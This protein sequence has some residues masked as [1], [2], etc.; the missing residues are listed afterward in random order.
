MGMNVGEFAHAKRYFSFALQRIE[1]IQRPRIC[2]LLA[3]VDVLLKKRV[4]HGALYGRAIV[5]KNTIQVA[6]QRAI[7]LIQMPKRISVQFICAFFSAFLALELVGAF[8]IEAT[9][10]EYCG[11]R[12]IC[13]KEKERP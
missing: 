5:V 4:V 3:E 13:P 12:H 9:I 10:D 7:F 8:A 6:P 11:L 2:L 1:E